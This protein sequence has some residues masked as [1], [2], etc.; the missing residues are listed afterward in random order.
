[1]EIID[2]ILYTSGMIIWG[3]HMLLLFFATGIYFSVKLRGIQIKKFIHSWRAVKCGIRERNKEKGDITQFQALTTSLSGTIGNGN[4]AGV[5][6][7][8]ALGG[9]GAIF[10]MWISGFLGMTTKFV[11]VVLGLKYRKTNPDGSIIGGPMY[12][13]QEGLGWKW[14]AIVFTLGMGIKTAI[15]TS[16]V[17]SNSISVAF[18]SQFG[19]PMPISGFVMAVGTLIVIIGG[20]KTIGKVTEILA[21]FMALLYLIGGF[22]TLIIYNKFLP[23]ILLAIIKNAFTGRAAA[24]GFIGATFFS[25]IRYGVARGIYSNEAG[26]GSS[27]IAHAAAKTNEPVR[28]GLIAMIDV[29]V[30]TI[31]ICTLTGL[32][33]LSTGEWVKGT[34]STEMTANAFNSGIPIVGGLIVTLSSFLFGYTTLIS[35]SY[36]GEQCFS[37]IFGIGVKKIFRWFYC[38]IIFFGGLFKVETVWN[39]GDTLNGIMAIPNII[40]ILWLSREVINLTKGYF[41]K[42]HNI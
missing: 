39:I 21:P 33:V 29:F 34:T 4:I 23:S 13:I 7:A 31:V 42:N 10:W 35:W 15:S 1:M 26:T 25:A 22:V 40:A 38:I 28:Q 6:T 17:Q 2:K 41:L 36:Y 5:A 30:D 32:V 16:M 11:E 19:I 3:P 27:P 14:L 24:G 8:V 18:K 37:Y 12:Y 9:P 20:I